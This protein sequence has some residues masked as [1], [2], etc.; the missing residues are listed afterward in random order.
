MYVC[1]ASSATLYS[2]LYS[3]RAFTSSPEL[4]ELPLANPVE[5]E[6]EE[7]ETEDVEAL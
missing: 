2:K 3:A 1:S 7:E 4:R 5:D 6:D